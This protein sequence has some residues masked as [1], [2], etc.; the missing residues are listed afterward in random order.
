MGRRTS[1]LLHPLGLRD[2]L[3]QVHPDLDVREALHG[4]EP[5]RRPD[6]AR[7]AALAHGGSRDLGL[8]ARDAYDH[9]T[10]LRVVLDLHVVSLSAQ[11]S[12]GPPKAWGPGS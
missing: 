1:S 8:A 10:G 7:L 3:D 9:L 6:H 2:H 12:V 4:H 5:L 11:R